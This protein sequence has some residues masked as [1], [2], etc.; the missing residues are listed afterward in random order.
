LLQQGP[1]GCEVQPKE[2]EM[3]QHQPKAACFLDIPTKLAGSQIQ[4]CEVM[5]NC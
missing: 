1:Q 4:I 5:K 2:Y 3:M